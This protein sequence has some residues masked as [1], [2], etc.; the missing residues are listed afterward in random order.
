MICCNG[1]K[2]PGVFMVVK[3]GEL[4][5]DFAWCGKQDCLTKVLVQIRQ[6]LE[7]LD[8]SIQVSLIQPTKK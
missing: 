3:I 7:P 4:T 2:E 8:K 5:N 6:T 1:C